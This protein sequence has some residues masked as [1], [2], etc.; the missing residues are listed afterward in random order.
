MV[1]VVVAAGDTEML[2]A[3]GM[4][5]GPPGLSDTAVALVVLHVSTDGCPAGIDVGAACNWT[6]TVAAPPPELPPPPGL[7]APPLLDGDELVPPQA[8]SRT[9]NRITIR[10][11]T[12]RRAAP[13]TPDKFHLS[14]GSCLQNLKPQCTTELSFSR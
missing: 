7:P 4:L 2:P 1:Y 11:E 3:S 13:T 5:A 14:P 9:K 12:N 6:V 8:F 10:T